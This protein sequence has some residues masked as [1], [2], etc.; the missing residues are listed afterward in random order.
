MA[1]EEVPDRIAEIFNGTTIFITGASGF[2]GK[3][4]IEKLLRLTN[5]R[6][7]YLLLREK[8][9]KSP[10]QRLQDIFTNVLYDKLKSLKPHALNKCTAIQGDVS[11]I[12][13]GISKED[14]ERLKN[15]V[16]FIFHS[17]ATTRFDDTLK[18]AVIMNTRGTMYMLRLAEECKK[19]KLFVHVST[20]YAFPREKVLYEKA[21]EPIADPQE[22]L[23]S[24]S[25]IKDEAMQEMQDKIL[26]DI[27]NAYTFSK[28]L[29]EALV[30]EKV[31]KIPVIIGR[32]A[33]VIPAL[34][35]PLPG[36]FNN[37]QGPMGLFAASG[38]GVIRSMYMDS[39]SYANLVPIDATVN[40]LM[41]FSWYYLKH[42]K[43]APWIYNICVPQRDIKLTWTEVMEHGKDVINTRVPFNNIMWYP[44]GAMTKNRLYN[45][46]NIFLF[47]II[48]AV[49]IDMIFVVLGYKPI[50][51][52]IQMRIKKGA[53]MFEFYTTKAWD[54]DTK[55]V[56]YVRSKLNSKEKQLYQLEADNFDVKDYLAN[57]ILYCRRHILKETDD[58][59]PAAR[60]NM[61]IMFA[62]DRTVKIT[63]FVFIAYY[64][65]KYVFCSIFS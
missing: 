54:F 63:F 45:K 6:K 53:E 57:G 7:M 51:Y 43:D 24:L 4:L 17:A 5:L 58:M 26:G 3:A 56:E 52:N 50:L 23:S 47:Q 29:A 65:Y 41:V 39:K 37:L 42:K 19:L 15:E 55:N 18:Y 61:K 28:S 40:A 21:Y 44:G 60:R 38:K 36:W 32:P 31:G 62:L 2:V 16:D 13:L 49:F 1:A 59:L 35:D 48:P 9:G 11:Q 27:P 20:A 22:V 14:R 46:V 64:F 10:E 34:W 33:V 25:W 30:Y 12:D 8:K